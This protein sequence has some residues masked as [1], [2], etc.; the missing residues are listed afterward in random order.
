MTPYGVSRRLTLT[1]NVTEKH[2]PE[3]WWTATNP[4]IVEWCK[5]HPGALDEDY[6]IV[7]SQNRATAYMSATFTTDLLSAS[8]LKISG[9]KL[10]PLYNISGC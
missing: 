1:R 6:P 3:E 10:Q 7:T 2:L 9:T 5:R 4:E 8:G